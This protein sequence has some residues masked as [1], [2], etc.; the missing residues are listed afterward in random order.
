M[1]EIP[2]PTDF[3]FPRLDEAQ[4]ARLAP[5]GRQLQAQAGEIVMDQGD[6]HRGVFVV[7]T[8]SIDVLGV[9]A[10]GEAVLRILGPGEFNGEVNLLSGRRSLV[11]L[12]AREA[13][14]VLEID[15]ANLRRI[16]QT[17][18]ALGEIFLNAFIQR[19]VYLVAHSL[20]DAVLIG[21]SHSSDTLR[22]REFLTRNGHPHTY[23]DVETDPDVHTLVEQFGFT[24]T[25]IPVLI[26]RGET[27]LR[28]PSNSE[29][30]ACFGLND[31]INQGELCDLV[32]V[33]AGPSGLAA[34]VYGASEGLKVMVL[35]RNAP[36]GQAGSSSRIE[37][38]LGFPMGISGQELS[39]RAFVQA[40]KFGAR[41]AIARSATGLKARRP[42]YTL[43]LDDGKSLRARAVIMAAGSRYR[44][45]DLPN[46]T[47]FE[48]VGIYYGATHVEGEACRGLEIAVVGG[49]NSAGQAALYLSSIASH[50]YL[51]VRGPSLAKTMSQYLISRIEASPQIT[52]MT[53]TRIDALEGSEH[54][55]RIHW[56]NTKTGARGIHQTR[57]VFVMTGA[58]PNTE[59]LTG[60]VE[61]DSQGFVKTGAEV[62]PAWPL[63]RSPYMLETSLPGV[64]AVGDIRAGSVKRVASAVGEGSMAVQFVHKVLAE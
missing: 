7:L 18:V 54:L 36:G 41:I 3:M 10:A 39:N 16:M 19:R 5:F 20:G 40:E 48:G 63:R 58:D 30:A 24:V 17:D 61:L 42:P 53:W 57:H 32:V 6:S 47:Q 64:F 56:L 33:G 13:A 50:V 14:M 26:C 34:A 21:S 11:R 8:G 1:A 46:L 4:I 44:R 12:R 60:S 52:V 55:E 29:A 23:L 22:L 45:L 35:E 59:W 2:Q 9:S 38:Y 51:L 43:D 28:N 37:N 49:G 25:D 27:A 62:G 31:E 15:R